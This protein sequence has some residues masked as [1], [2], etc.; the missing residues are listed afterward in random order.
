[1]KTIFFKPFF[2]LIFLFFNSTV[3]FA[4]DFQGKAYYFSKTTM[5][6]SRFGGGRQLN[7]QQKKEMEARMKQWLER[8]YVL[9]FNKNEISNKIISICDYLGLEKS[10]DSFIKWIMD[11]F[12]YKL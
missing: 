9:T 1:M 7:E 11:L 6:M 12:I 4:Q 2:V 3:L 10:F 8:T 5:D